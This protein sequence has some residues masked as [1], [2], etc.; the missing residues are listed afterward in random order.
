MTTGVL[1]GAATVLLVGAV[2]LHL[3]RIV[4][5][6]SSLAD[7]VVAVDSALIAFVG[8]LAVLTASSGRADHADLVLVISLLAFIGT[9]TVAR[10]IERRGA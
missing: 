3:L 5:R 1:T 2:A 9:V 7:R 10:Y 8:L 4:R 6:D